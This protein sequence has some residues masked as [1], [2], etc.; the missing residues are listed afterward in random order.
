MKGVYLLDAC[1]IVR[2]GS[3]GARRDDDDAESREF[4]DRLERALAPTPRLRVVAVFDG[5]RRYRASGGVLELRFAEGAT[6]DAVILDLARACVHRGLS[7][8]VVSRDRS[9]IERAEEE[10]ARA[11]SPEAFEARLAR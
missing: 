6:A 2:A 5:P 9:L 4:I 11:L 3:W 7:V 10:G 1:N 8:S